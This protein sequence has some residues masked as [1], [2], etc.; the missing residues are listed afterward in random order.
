MIHTRFKLLLGFLGVW[1]TTS[2]AAYLKYNER[3]LKYPTE[4]GWGPALQKHWDYWKAHFNSGGLITATKPNGDVANVSEAQA[5]GMLLALWFNDKA[6]FDEIYKTTQDKFW[7]GSNYAWI[8]SPSKDPNFAGD[9]DQDIAGAL[10]F[11]SALVDSSAVTGWSNPSN[12]APA[13]KTQAKTVLASIGANFI[14]GSH[15]IRAWNGKSGLYNPSYHMPGWIQIFKEF[16]AANGVTDPGWDA[17]RTAEYGLFN[18]EPNAKYGMARNWSSDPGNGT[19]TPSNTDMSF[20]AIRVPYRIGIDAIWYPSHTQAVAW[21]Q[22]V[23]DNGAVKA[24]TAGMYLVSSHTLWG[25]GTF[26]ASGGAYSDAQYEWALTVPMWGTAAVAV[27]SSTTGATAAG[28]SIARMKPG[29]NNQNYF[30]L[31]ANTDT[32]QKSSPNKNYYAQSL[33][34]LGTLAMDG[35]AWNVWDDLK[36][37][38]TVKDTNATVTAALKATPASVATG[39][40]TTLTA[41][42]SHAITWTMIIK[43]N[44][45]GASYTIGPKTS[46]SIS[47]TW[48]SNNHK[49]GAS[50]SATG[51]TVTASVTAQW[52]SPPSGASTTITLG[53]SG[54]EATRSHLSAFSW[55]SEGLRLPVGL[56]DEG[57]SVQVRVLDLSGRQVGSARSATAHASGDATVLDLAPQRTTQAGLVELRTANGGVERLLLPPVR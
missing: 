45:S 34:L 9:A 2:S 54:I 13:Y 56:A 40:S 47:E 38:W 31:S 7:G 37:P 26:N 30:V 10:I 32:T 39:V 55:T 50:F 44:T 22:S 21:C 51:E 36:N 6:A 52:S 18:S 16:G 8:I 28:K 27:K 25:W 1:A 17:V 43:G 49:I 53:A 14:D 33:A 15:L 42:F 57:Q 23:W 20:D 24:D 3:I 46:A 5:Y 11:A 19:E 12:G 41:T 4:Q 48:N 35:L 29:V